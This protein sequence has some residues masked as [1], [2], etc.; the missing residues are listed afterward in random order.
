MIT[1]DIAKRS[2]ISKGSF[3]ASPKF[4]RGLCIIHPVFRVRVPINAAVQRLLGLARAEARR[5][6][7]HSPLADCQG[8]RV[9]PFTIPFSTWPTA[10]RKREVQKERKREGEM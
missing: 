4:S 3:F 1:N 10:K 5:G 6:N 7:L 9:V 2:A 8:R